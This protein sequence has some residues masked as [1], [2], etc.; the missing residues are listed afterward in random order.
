MDT[1]SSPLSQY[2]K[3]NNPSKN[4]KQLFTNHFI[5][6]FNID[7]AIQ[8]LHSNLTLIKS[9]MF[10][11]IESNLSQ[12][13]EPSISLEMLKSLYKSSFTDYK[14]TLCLY[15]II[16]LQSLLSSFIK[17][18]SPFISTQKKTIEDLVTQSHSQNS[19]V[20]QLSYDNFKQGSID[21]SETSKAFNSHL[22]EQQS[23]I[24]DMKIQSRQLED[25]ISMTNIIRETFKDLG[26]MYENYSH[27]LLTKLR[28]ITKGNSLI[29]SN[30]KTH[31]NQV[32]SYYDLLNSIYYRKEI[33]KNHLKKIKQLL[34]VHFKGNS[35][36]I[37]NAFINSNRIMSRLTAFKLVNNSFGK[38]IPIIR[39]SFLLNKNLRMREKARYAVRDVVICLNAKRN[40]ISDI[41]DNDMNMLI[42][43]L[44]DY[45]RYPISRFFISNVFQL[46]LYGMTHQLSHELY[47]H[48]V[49][50]S[51]KP[52]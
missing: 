1:I 25:N 16:D 9:S 22:L 3:N 12:S 10:S 37:T 33:P 32:E 46:Y 38:V 45:E 40:M 39:R 17:A 31:L 7:Q 26:L 42:K 24:A 51:I 23:E 14:N 11:A 28:H 52:K 5:D 44:N 41:R 47:D 27:N 20:D 2:I 49:N 6:I 21:Y 43:H 18:S 48:Y 35:E 15:N 8:T 34:S 29:A 13:K 19:K 50:N 4:S 36:L 30:T